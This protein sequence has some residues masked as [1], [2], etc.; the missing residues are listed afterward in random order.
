MRPGQP[1]RLLSL[2]AIGLLALS[3]QV[4]LA[5]RADAQQVAAQQGAARQMQAADLKAWKNIRQ[6]MLSSDGKWF[7]YTL[8][9]NEGAATLVTR[10]TSADAKETKYPIGEIPAA[11]G[12]GRGGA[13]DASA[14]LAIS[15]DSRW[16]AYTIY[17]ATRAGRGAGRGAGQPGAAATP[18][19][20]NKLG[21]V[22]LA[23]GEKKEFD[24]VRRFAF[25]GDKPTWIAMQ[26][27]P[28]AASGN[29]GAQGGAA[30]R[31]AAGGADS[32]RVQGSDLVLYSL[33]TGDAVNV[34]NVSEFGF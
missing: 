23:T 18:P 32:A 14:T 13:A 24:R 25:N 11:G 6:S 9:P 33:T 1:R 2:A 21:L 29:A 4:G 15:G 3:S 5:R 31:G 27:F 17:P 10:S 28:E 19:S 20:Q 22:N 34:G 26:S 8:A 12:G 7:V 16:V 30:G